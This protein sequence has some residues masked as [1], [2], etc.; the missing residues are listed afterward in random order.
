M[1][2]TIQFHSAAQGDMAYACAAIFLTRRN[3]FALA[4]GFVLAKSRNAAT[5]RWLAL[6]PQ[7]DPALIG[8]VPIR[9]QVIEFAEHSCADAPPV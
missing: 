5:A 2:L 6:C 1:P 8:A 7:K 4:N 3:K 9:V